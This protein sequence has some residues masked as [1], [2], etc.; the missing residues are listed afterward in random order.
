MKALLLITASAL[1]MLTLTLA[2]VVILPRIADY[3]NKEN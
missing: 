1:Y 3:L 2:T